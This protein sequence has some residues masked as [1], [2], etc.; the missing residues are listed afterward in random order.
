LQGRNKEPE[1][2]PENSSKDELDKLIIQT[3]KEEKPESIR[4][5]V[6]LMREKSEASEQK[7]V[8]RVFYLQQKGKIRLTSQSTVPPKSFS[9][10]LRSSYAHWYWI[11]VTLTLAT[12][13]VVFVVPEDDFPLV[14][15]RYALGII[16]IMWLPGYAF[17]KALF[18]QGLPWA[19]A[20]AHSLGTSEK[21][22][23]QI[24]RAALSLGMSIALVPIVG[25]LLNYTP[26]GI[27]LSSIVLSLTALTIVFATAAILREQQMTIKQDPDRVE[28]SNV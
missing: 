28:Q 23:D 11:T 1:G 8:N 14:Y 15:V 17:I 5:L 20:L 19:R 27:R 18:P 24:E 26:W 21:N 25:L 13:L 2:L 6:D 10:Y 12:L 16:F 3:V 22:L 7:I 9:Y 4:Q